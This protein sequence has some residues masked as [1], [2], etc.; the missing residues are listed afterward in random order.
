MRD[1]LRRGVDALRRSQ[2]VDR[3]ELRAVASDLRELSDPAF[4][5][6]AWS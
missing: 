5:D 1:A 2:P 3:D 4:E 6:D